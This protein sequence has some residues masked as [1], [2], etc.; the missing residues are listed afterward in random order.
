MQGFELTKPIEKKAKKGIQVIAL[1]AAVLPT[2][3]DEADGL[4]LGK[5]AQRTDLCVWSSLLMLNVSL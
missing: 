3:E 4:S 5:I 2:P 1:A